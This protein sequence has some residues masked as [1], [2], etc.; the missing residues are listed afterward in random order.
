MGQGLGVDRLVVI[1]WEIV[2]DVARVNGVD[3]VNRRQRL[4]VR[5]EVVWH[6]WLVCGRLVV[7][8]RRH[9][10]WCQPEHR[11]QAS[12]LVGGSRGMVDWG[13]GWW[14][15]GRGG[16]IVCRLGRAEVTSF[17]SENLL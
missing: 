14:V 10:L 11:L 17:Q 1:I 15:I 7:R 6:F 13:R 16:G 2:H 8:D 3:V 4:G 12:G 9:I 5:V